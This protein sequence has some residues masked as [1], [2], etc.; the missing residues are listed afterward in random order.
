MDFPS[1]VQV[2]STWYVSVCSSTFG[3]LPDGERTQIFQG[4]PNRTS[5]Y[6]IWVPSGDQRGS[7]ARTGG[8][9]SCIFSLPSI[10][11]RH[12]VMSGYETYASHFPSNEKSTGPADMPA[13]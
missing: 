10:R 1:G 8:N 3:L 5:I 12:S 4:W 2:G 9:V 13:R 6:A 11:L 7:Y